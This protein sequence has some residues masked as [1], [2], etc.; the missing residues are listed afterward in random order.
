MSRMAAWY[1]LSILVTIVLVGALAPISW[2]DAAVSPFGGTWPRALQK[3]GHVTVFAVA[4]IPMVILMPG[5]RSSVTVLLLAFSASIEA[6]QYLSPT[7]QPSFLDV[8]IDLAGVCLG[9]AAM[10]LVTRAKTSV[11][12]PAGEASRAVSDVG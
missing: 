12:E 5:R 11:P 2:Y 3:A 6:L 1:L 10:A 7:R 8:G 4:V 9:F